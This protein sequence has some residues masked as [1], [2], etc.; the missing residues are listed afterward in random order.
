MDGVK[1][2]QAGY[3]ARTCATSSLITGNIFLHLYY[4]ACALFAA[5]AVF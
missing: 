3:V 5:I 1:Y 4:F 2:G